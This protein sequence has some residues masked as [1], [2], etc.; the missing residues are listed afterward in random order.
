GR[1]VALALAH[2]GADLYLLD[3]DEAGLAGVVAQAKGWG[4]DVIGARCDLIHPENIT[5]AVKSIPRDWGYIDIL[6]NK[7]AVVYYG[8]TQRMTADQWSSLL[9]INLLA[10]IQLTCEWLPILLT[11][12]EAHILNV[13]S[14][15]GLVSCGKLAAYHTSKHGLVGF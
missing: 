4:V 15:A 9:A 3:I 11:R 2:A 12:P 7:D 13:C 1:A 8:P 6:I 14:I 5:G 10:P